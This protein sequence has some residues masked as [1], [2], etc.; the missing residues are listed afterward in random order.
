MWTA[1]LIETRRLD[2]HLYIHIAHVYERG[3][4]QKNL[5]ESS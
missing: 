4:F 1:Y 2:D 5:T 3:L